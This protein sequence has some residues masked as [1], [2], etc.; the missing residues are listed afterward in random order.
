MGA[1]ARRATAVPPTPIPWPP[2]PV[3]CGT[4]LSEH[5]L[6]VEKGARWQRAAVAE[7]HGLSKLAGVTCPAGLHAGVRALAVRKN[8]T[9][10]AR[11]PAHH[12]G[13]A[14]AGRCQA[15]TRMRTLPEC[16]HH[17]MA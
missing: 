16:G 6:H 9:M 17:C 12:R 11:S 2:A 10:A 8:S 15:G 14:L 3:E 1:A 13:S 7:G 4:L 5:A